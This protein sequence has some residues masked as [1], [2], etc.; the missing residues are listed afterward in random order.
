MKVLN[1]LSL[2]ICGFSV[3]WVAHSI[4]RSEG[5]VRGP[6][7]VYSSPSSLSILKSSSRPNDTRSSN[8][9]G[10][11]PQAELS[12][13]Q[14][15]GSPKNAK[16][17]SLIELLNAGQYL[18]AIDLFQTAQSDNAKVAVELRRELLAYMTALMAADS[19]EEFTELAD[20]YLSYV[21]DDVDV[22]LLL[23]EFNKKIDYYSEAISIYQLAKEYAYRL[24]A[25]KKVKAAFSLFLA[26]VDQVLAAQQDWYGLAQVYA[27]AELVELLSSRQQLR[28]AE[29]YLSGEEHYLGRQVIT[30]LIDQGKLV[31]EAKSLLAQLNS[32]GQNSLAQ[33]SA[34]QY[35]TAV[36]LEKYGNQYLV[37]LVLDDQTSV[38]LLMDTGASVT[39][40][41]TSAFERIR[42]DVDTVDVATRMFNTANGLAKGRIVR[43]DS[44]SL[45]EFS[46]QDTNIAILDFEMSGGIDGLLGM[47]VLG[48]FKFQIEPTGPK[49][50]LTPR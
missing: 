45:G 38:R 50:L 40:L 44:V 26:D 6:T 31:S 24:D 14:A 15:V 48:A 25:K 29:V 22:L 46:L 3:G 39:T 12:L 34:S 17:P 28:F 27:Q 35:E 11:N 16:S 4:F 37:N 20:A 47:N 41:S 21:F 43:V 18:E 36:A 7:A 23:A 13:V 30:Q 32:D 5:A 49:L 8:R 33:D 42:G 19:R 1:V 10:T 9:R 2:L